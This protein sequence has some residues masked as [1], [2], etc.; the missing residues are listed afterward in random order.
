MVG[1]R[2]FINIVSGPGGT[3][4]VPAH[5][6]RFFGPGQ[7]CLDAQQGDMILVR[8]SSRTAKAIRAAERLRVQKPYCWTN[9]AC[10][11]LSGGPDAL[12]IQETGK[13]SIVTPLAE[14]VMESYSVTHF[15]TVTES[16][17]TAGAQFLHCTLGSGYGFLTIGADLINALTGLDIGLGIGNRMV[18]STQTCRYL[19]RLGL[20]PDRSP[21]AVTPAHLAWYFDIAI[22]RQGAQ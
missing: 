17:M 18:C 21:Y 7:V 12:V 19:E 9:H 11:A 2:P 8:H 4:I 22:E 3:T 1:D 13:G 20:V 5:S 6:T 14:M 10:V 16:Q 15:D